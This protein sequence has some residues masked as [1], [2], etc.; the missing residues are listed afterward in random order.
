MIKIGLTDFTPVDKIIEIRD[1]KE[2]IKAKYAI[3]ATD[4]LKSTLMNEHYIEISFQYNRYIAFKR[5]DYILW[6]GSKY[7]LREDY[8]PEQINKRKYDYTLRFEAVEM[9]FQDIQYYYLN[10]SLK[11]SEW[12]LAGNPEYF[13]KIAVD[14]ANRYFKVTDFQTGVIE[15]TEVKDIIFDT[16]TNTFDALTQIA[17]AY[18]SEWYMTG[19][20]INLVKKVSFGAEVDF[21]TEVSILSMSRSEGENSKKYTRILALGSERNL[22]KD[23]RESS[24]GEGVDAVY[25]KRLRIPAAKGDVIDAYPNM[26]PD[27]VVEGTVIFDEVYPKRVGTIQAVGTIEYTDTDEDTGEVTKWNAFKIKDSGINFKEEYLLPG[28]ELR[29]SM[30]SGDLNGFDFALKFHKDGFSKTDNSQYFEIVRSEDYGKKLPNDTM[31]PKAEDK[32]VL[33]GF[34]IALVSDQYVP[35][36][37]LELFDTASAWIKKQLQDTSV[38]DCPTVIGHFKKNDM[39]LEIGQKVKLKHD[40]FDNRTRSSRIMG[41]E[42]KLI[43]IYDATYTIGDNS[44]YSRLASIEKDLKEIQYA[45]VV[46]ENTGTR[47]VYLIKQFDTTTPTDFN[48]YSAK[49]SDAKYFNKQTGGTIQGDTTFDRNMQV[50]G[51]AITDVFQ[52]STF[53]AGQFGS[54]YQIKKDANGQSY[55]EVDNI[56]VRREAVFNKLTI[57]EIK[58]IGGAI[59]LSLANM[60]VSKVEDKTSAWKC[61]FDNLDG[62]VLNKFAVNDQ[63]I[64]RKYTGQDI[65][66][67]WTL[68]TAVGPDYIEISKTDKDGLSIPAIGDEIIQFGNRTDVNRQYAIMLSAYGS[69]A[70]SIKQYAAINSYDLTGKEVT[71]LSPKGNK[72]TGSFTVSTNGTTAPVYKERQVFVNGTVYYLNDRV[73]HL[74]SYWVCIVSSTNKTPHEESVDWRKDTVGQTDIDNIRKEYKSDFVVLDTKIASKVSQTDFDSLGGRVA[75]TESNITQLSNSITSVV[76]KTGIDHIGDNESLY[77]MIKQTEDKITLEVSSIKVGSQNLIVQSKIKNN[78][79]VDQTTG[80]ETQYQGFAA[81]DF[82]FIGDPN[83]S[84]TIPENWQKGNYSNSDGTYHPEVANYICQKSFTPVEQNKKYLIG[85]NNAFNAWILLY[86]KAYSF[87]RTI[88]NPNDIITIPSNVSFIRYNVRKQDSSNIDLSALNQLDNYVS[89]RESSISISI[90]NKIKEQFRNTRVVFF[91]HNREYLKGISYGGLAWK[92]QTIEA[93]GNAQYVRFS[94]NSTINSGNKVAKEYWKLEKGNKI[95]EWNLSPEDTQSSIDKAQSTADSKTT[96]DEVSSSLT[97]TDNKISLASKTIE[98]KGTTIAKAIEAENLKVGSRTGSSALEVLKDGTFY[99]KGSSGTNQ[100][101]TIDSGT[102]SVNLVTPYSVS[103]NG[104]NYDLV[105]PTSLEISSKTGGVKIQSGSK[106]AI[107]STEGVYAN[108]AGQNV[109]AGSTGIN[110]RAAIVGI[111]QANISQSILNDVFVAGVYGRASNLS[112]APAYGGYFD[113]LRANG[114]VMSMINISESTDQGTY[115]N[116]ETSFVLGNSEVMQTVYLPDDAYPGTL[117]WLKQWYTGY[118]RIRPCGTQRLFDDSSQN[119]YIDVGEGWT[120][121]CV[122]IGDWGKGATSYGTWMISKFRF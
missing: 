117:I 113:M 41:F 104:S 88:G 29:L 36:G 71:T 92:E 34:N 54:G 4:I 109:Y 11:E 3:S 106:S 8:I 108:Y 83:Q 19:K 42:K 115:L 50:Q 57:A 72:F 77:S 26:S 65:K 56:L 64:C 87:I 95:T 30:Q 7:T 75:K 23:Y 120:A 97:L 40:Q 59:L 1:K 38:Y 20:T 13:I 73:S 122:F 66:Y 96:L 33:Y 52:N 69:D 14:N 35:A 9:L 82:I 2:V 6:N 58:S 89:M 105:N 103:N 119:D 47:G 27:E 60:V 78:Y 68:V 53:T 86:D 61:Y 94:A 74:G 12:R 99:A 84:T 45:G 51:T 85:C 111:G 18:E 24:T 17:E 93:P 100:S 37:E 25:P 44:A 102:Q 46:Y 49:A 5:S 76:Q 114:F 62:T 107:V 63:V 98:L 16:N 31:K 110:Q 67:Y 28:V 91:N 116:R 43:N 112:T 15:P 118:M 55:L 101:L 32:Y 21:E 48:V 70:P 10:Q 39:D 22:P 81:T 121:M 90:S 80:T 79:Y